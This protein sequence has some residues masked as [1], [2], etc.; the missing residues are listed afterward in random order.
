MSSWDESR[1][2]FAEAADWFVRTTT[3]V[4]D[5]WGQP[6]LGEWDVRALV[7]HTS[8][9][10]LTVEAYLQQPADTV[11]VE[12]PAEYFRAAREVAPPETVAVRGREAGDALGPDP[13]AAV[14]GIAGRVVPLVRARTGDEVVT[15]VVGGMRLAGYLPT[16][17]FELVVHTCD[18]VSALGIHARPPAPAAAQALTVMSD[19]AVEGGQA[20]RLLLAA[21]GR[22]QDTFTVL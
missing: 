17:T 19:L 22:S 12:S 2:A 14:A 4:G 15:T 5:R 1:R 21:T 10:L 18:L 13:A 9:A 7:G 20:G 6:G 3:Q 8:R 16:R 11:D